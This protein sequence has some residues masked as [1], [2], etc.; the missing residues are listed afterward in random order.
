MA[1][2]STPQAVGSDGAD[3]R[4]LRR[5]VLLVGAAVLIDTTFYAVVAP[6]L[7]QLSHALHLSKLGAGVLTACY[8]AGMLL[9]SL[10]GG[11]LAVALGPRVAL[12]IGL[13]LLFASTVAFALLHSTLGLDTARFC[14]GVGGAFSWDGGVAW[15]VLAAPA[16]RRGT[17]IGQAVSAAIAGSVAGPA[18]GALASATGRAALFIALATL[19]LV[20]V[21]ATWLVRAPARRLEPDPSDP[22]V[23]PRRAIGSLLGRPLGRGALWMMALPAM[24]AGSLTVLGSLRLHALGAGAGVIGATFIGASI[25]ETATS[26]GVGVVSDRRGRLA[27]L[28]V[29]FSVAGAAIACFS[30]A[31]SAVALVAVIALS[32]AG[33]GG[34]WTPVMALLADLSEGVGLDQ[35]LGAGLMNVAW[36]TGQILGSGGGGALA[37][38]AGDATVT[39]LLGACLLLTA[40]VLTRHRGA[41]LTASPG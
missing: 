9:A 32:T 30:A 29:A 26:S 7:P 33:L 11:Y 1:A 35:A 40:A 19:A 4:E 20:L 3:P 8:A 22:I 13:G 23:S 16:A 25:L 36:A 2:A 27:P 37:R 10:P 31:P 21:L 6:L 39:L 24:A 5:L 15:L 34:A 14:E 38:L 28:I 18:V 12:S 17:V 41:V